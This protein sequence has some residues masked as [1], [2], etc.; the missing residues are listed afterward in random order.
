[1]S[2]EEPRTVI[3]PGAP[4]PAFSVRLGTKAFMVVVSR[5]QFG[6]LCVLAK[7]AVTLGRGNGVA[8]P[9][10]SNREQG[11]LPRFGARGCGP[12]HRGLRIDQ[13]DHRQR[14][15]DRGPGPPAL[16]RPDQHR[17]YDREVLHRGDSGPGTGNGTWWTFHRSVLRQETHQSR[18][19]APAL[20]R[21]TNAARCISSGSR[22]TAMKSPKDRR[23]TSSMPD[24][25]RSAPVPP[26][27][28]RECYRRPSRI[29]CSGR[30]RPV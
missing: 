5:R 12:R 6:L 2:S 8:W 13:R 9:Q 19:V 21:A 3:Q 27:A 15:P 22:S 18:V 30:H 11:T 26:R 14:Q 4:R 16:R 17:L 29:C 10:R 20:P 25:S 1:M 23:R 7:S 24:A 28:G